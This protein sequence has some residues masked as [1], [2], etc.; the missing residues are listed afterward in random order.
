MQQYCN[1]HYTKHKVTNTCQTCKQQAVNTTL[2][3]YHQHQTLRNI[4]YGL[5]LGF[6]HP[7]ECNYS[8]NFQPCFWSPPTSEGKNLSLDAPCVGSNCYCY[9]RFTVFG[10][11]SCRMSNQNNQLRHKLTLLLRER[12]KLEY[13]AIPTLTK[14]K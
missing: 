1:D 10:L 5:S 6:L 2:M 13:C 3:D 4:S 12:Q 8:L 14:S 11:Q 9:H 7:N